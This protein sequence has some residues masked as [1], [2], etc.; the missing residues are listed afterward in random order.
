MSSEGCQ[1]HIRSKYLQSFL[2]IMGSGIR[3]ELPPVRNYAL[4]MLGQFSEFIHPEIS[5]HAP[6]ILPVLLD[7]LDRALASITPGAKDPSTVSR[8]FY[9]L[10]TFCEN[11]EMKLVPHL[12]LIMS[13]ATQAME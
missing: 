7:Y 13:R 2:Q 10:E 6:D 4:Y 9:A 3:H 8:V 1:E 11:L 12:E 5:N